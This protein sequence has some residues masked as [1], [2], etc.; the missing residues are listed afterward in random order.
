MLMRCMIA[1]NGENAEFCQRML[2]L[3]HSMISKTPHLV[4]DRLR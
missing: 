4:P 1:L 3:L 2:K